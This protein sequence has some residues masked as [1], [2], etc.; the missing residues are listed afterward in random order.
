MFKYN[1]LPLSSSRID[2]KSEIANVL[3]ILGESPRPAEKWETLKNLA[4]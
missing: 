4:E 2:C 3:L 1:I